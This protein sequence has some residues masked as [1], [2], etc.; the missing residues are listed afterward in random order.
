LACEGYVL[1]RRTSSA[2]APYPRLFSLKFSL[3]HY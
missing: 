2:F 1:H 3:A